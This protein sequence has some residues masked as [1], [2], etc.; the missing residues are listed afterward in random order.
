LEPSTII[1]N[2][3]IIII[4]IIINAHYNYKCIISAEQNY[5]GLL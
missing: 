1:I 3:C 4:I 2:Y 5:T